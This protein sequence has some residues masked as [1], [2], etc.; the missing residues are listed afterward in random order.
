MPGYLLVQ[1]SSLSPPLPERNGVKANSRRIGLL[2]FLRELAQEDFPFDE[3]S[4]LLVEGMEDVLL[5]ARTSKDTE[6]QELAEAARLIHSRLQKAANAFF[7]RGCPDV[8]IVFRQ[9]LQRGDHLIVNHV[10]APLPV[11]LIFGSP[12]SDEINGQKVYRTS[13]NLSAP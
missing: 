9:P 4:S 3:N 2:D 10:T 6:E 13:F 11:Y 1:K 7:A 12:P 5:A 8:Q